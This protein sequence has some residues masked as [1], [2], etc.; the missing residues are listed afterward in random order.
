MKKLLAVSIV[1]TVLSA[2]VFAQVKDGIS[3]GAWGRGTFV[4]IKAQTA[5]D[6]DAVLGAGVD[7]NYGTAPEVKF[8]IDGTA[9]EGFAGFRTETTFVDVTNAKAGDFAEL[10]VKPA[11][12]LRVDLGKYLYDELRGKYNNT[13][14]H[15]YVLPFY[16]TADDVF[17]RFSSDR[18]GDGTLGALVRLTPVEGLTIGA[19]FNG[20]NPFGSTKTV[21]VY[22]NKDRASHNW[23]THKDGVDGSGVLTGINPTTGEP[24]SY[25]WEARDFYS[26]IQIAVGYNIPN[27][28]LARVQYLGAEPSIAL[29][30]TALEAAIKNGTDYFT[31]ANVRAPTVQV[32]F[33]LTAVQDL[34]VDLGLTLPFKVAFDEKHSQSAVADTEY[35]KPI[36]IALV[37]RYKTGD[38]AVDGRVDTT[39]GGSTK[40]GD[41]DAEKEG[42][43]LQV[44]L[45][46]SYNLGF[47]VAG[48]ELGFAIKGTDSVGSTATD[49]TGGTKFG[50]GLWLQ[51][52]VANGYLKGGFG[53]QADTQWGGKDVYPFGSTFVIPIVAG[54]SF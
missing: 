52:N 34:T 24:V 6:G 47:V 26:N 10:W 2:T 3:V 36:T 50:A 30:L 28:G 37:A 23:T 17:R 9:G 51:K 49:D 54:I 22:A 25:K 16:K 12:W 13:D 53:F 32:A 7:V 31:N 19:N 35:Q 45:V 39:L 29:S 5:H 33:A 20:P 38:F 41:A 14:Y 27:I 43:V 48:A 1:L 42:L 21:A 40:V 11:S 4:P 8:Q 46:P 44:N 18:N 15:N